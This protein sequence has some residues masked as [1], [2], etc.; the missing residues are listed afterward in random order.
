[1]K[2]KHIKITAC[3]SIV[4]IV[5]LLVCIFMMSQIDHSEKVK[6]GEATIPTITMDYSNVFVNTLYGYADE[7]DIPYV[8]DTITPV[9]ST[10]KVNIKIDKK[11]ED[12][13]EIKYEIVSLDGKTVISN[14]TG[15]A[16]KDGQYVLNLKN[17]LSDIE[18][19][20]EAVLKIMLVQGEKEYYYYT[21]ITSDAELNAD[22]CLNFAKNFQSN[23]FDKK[24]KEEVAKYLE[25]DLEKT[26]NTFEHVDITSNIYHVTWGNME[27]KII[28]DVVWDIKETNSVYTSLVSQYQVSVNDEEKGTEIF[29]I[30]EYYRVRFLRDKIYLLNF[31]RSMEQIFDPAGKVLTKDGI[32]I[33][34]ASPDIEYAG[35]G[36][37]RYTA[38]VQE[39][40]LWLYD[41]TNEEFSYIFG[42]A[43]KE[44][45]DLRNK[46]SQHEIRIIDVDEKGNIVFTVSGYMNRG[47]NEG[48]TGVAVC[49]YEKDENL[50]KEKAF[51]PDTRS[52][53]LASLHLG[54]M[55]Y[56]SP[57]MDTVS[58]VMN[59]ALYSLKS[60]KKN[61]D[62]LLTEIPDKEYKI[63]D[64]GHLFVCKTSK[65]KESITVFNFNS[66]E[67]YEINAPE[68]KVIKP[69]GFIKND[70][71]YGIASTSEEVVIDTSA[72]VL[73]IETIEIRDSKNEVVKEYTSPGMIITG[74]DVKDNLITVLRASE[75]GETYKTEKEDYISNNEEIKSKMARPDVFYTELQETQVYLSFEEENTQAHA[76]TVYPDFVFE[77]N[78]IVSDQK[79]D[80]KEKEYYV[81]GKGLPPEVYKD[82]SEAIIRAGKTAGVVVDENQKYVWEKGNRDLS[83][84]NKVESFNLDEEKTELERCEEALAA[85]PGTKTRLNGI[86]F[87]DI[88]YIINAGSP[89][90]AKVGE[91]KVILI[92]GYNLDN[93]EYIDPSDG[94]LHYEPVK[95][96]TEKLK[97]NGNMFAVNL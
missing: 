33:G 51:M 13:L 46:N 64:D 95:S 89:A 49:Y 88:C 87:S 17:S 54:Q 48:H 66:G 57:D 23:T 30:R 44:D 42:F 71:I 68:G 72:K 76:N 96:M 10:G 22:K 75:N 29:N 93:V 45:D 73:P 80:E 69:L 55:I 11:G 37:G 19:V 7:M 60:G 24:Q 21:R 94:E 26:N 32:V 62:V 1:M 90:I 74:I 63:S 67:S 12:P 2:K 84:F 4:T 34:I 27:P 58:Y 82:P 20:R 65:E 39:R 61:P 43:D 59:N 3:V 40:V 83:F 14:G 31:D 85:F 9:D 86:E 38:F 53:Y 36:D 70:I 8:R 50:V 52:G 15:K 81:Y 91:D 18:A 35:S 25:P 6:L 79:T 97:E 47:H 56:Y 92:T 28:S 16:A 41:K 77:K 5:T 78:V